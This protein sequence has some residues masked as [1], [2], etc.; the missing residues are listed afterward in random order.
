MQSL[1]RGFLLLVSR[2]NKGKN[3]T[4]RLISTPFAHSY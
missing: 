3:V 1:S 2:N 4:S